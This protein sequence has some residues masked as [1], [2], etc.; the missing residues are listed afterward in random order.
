MTS[1]LNLPQAVL[2]VLFYLFFIPSGFGQYKLA[3]TIPIDPAVRTGVLP[4]GLHYYIRENHDFRNVQLRLVVNAGS[5]LEDDD[6]L[7]L[8][9]FMEHMNFNGLKHFPKNELVTYLQSIGGSIG[10][11]LNANT[12]YDATN[13]I[14]WMTTGDEKKI[15]KG[16][17]ILSDWSHNALLDTTEI[18]KERGVVLEESRLHKTAIDR[19]RLAYLPVMLNGSKYSERVPIGKDSIIQHFRPEVLHR[20][21]D[22]WY[23]PDLEA[24]IVVGDIAADDIEKKIIKHFSNFVNPANETPRP[25]VILIPLRTKPAGLVVTDKE[26]QT[27]LF[28]LYN[29]IERRPNYVTWGDYRQKIVEQL[30]NVMLDER[31]AGMTQQANA[32]FFSG[33]ASF[34]DFF[35]DYRTFS[36]VLSTGGKPLQ[37]AIDSLMLALGS[38]RQYGFLDAEL[39]RAK[40]ALLRKANSAFQ[41][42]MKTPTAELV[43]EYVNNYL[44]GAPI[45]SH[46]DQYQ[47]VQQVLPTITRDDMTALEKK[48]DIGPGSFALVLSSDKPA[49]ASTG[50][51]LMADIAGAAQLQV[52]AHQEKE[53]GHSLMDHEPQAG[54][55]TRRD[56]DKQLGT[57]NL[58]LSNGITVTL[59][60]TDF[61]NDDIRMDAW[62][63]GGFHQYPLTDKYNAMNAAQVVRAM[64][65]EGFTKTELDKFLAGKAVHV[66][67]YLNPYEDGVEGNCGAAD[68]ETFLQLVNLYLTKPGIDR[69]AFQSFIDRQESLVQNLK[70][71]P[72]AYYTDTL[73]KIEYRNNP[74]ANAIPVPAD[75]AGIDLQR[76]MEIYKGTFSNCYGMHFT[77]VGSFDAETMAPLLEKYLGSLPA[78]KKENKYTDEG[79]RPVT[80]IVQ[81]SVKKGVASQGQV[82]IIFT[83]EGPY[84]REDILKLNLL[85][86]M[87]NVQIFQQL[88]EE[89]G[90]TYN[91]SMTPVFNKRP[92]EHY[93]VTARIP[94]AP[95]NADRMSA[96]LFDIINTVRDKGVDKD[97]MNKF[98]QN[99]M[100]H[101]SGQMKTNEYWLQSLSSSWID[102]EDP[103]WMND[104]YKMVDTISAR[105]LK[106]TANKYLNTSNYIKVQLL[107][108]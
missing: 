1:H 64:G 99:M 25:A 22:T 66:Q 39:E 27:T 103:S 4:N 58:T 74:W 30:F 100:N 67:P 96:A 92:Y 82:N 91:A 83:G 47:F 19:M 75:Y 88:R 80:G 31:L 89:M 90:G 87:L 26:F 102:V 105:E 57:I 12:G 93:S 95:E 23:R 45:I 77:F 8:A 81:T 9:H 68:L 13:Y 43:G 42:S 85:V 20:F 40:S 76:S 69:A 44:A 59:K 106:E 78:A 61:K 37:P 97:L 55:I 28:E 38:I 101:H 63:W 65:I 98:K 6:Q 2:L 72:M 94:C 60:P 41:E 79:M 48:L 14:L 86:G 107:P 51:Q 73:E 3:D 16:F 24:V 108:E 17:T 46:G 71:N 52:T 84:G 18:N 62:R 33:H 49:G 104:F 21:Y 7:G 15:E 36:S 11:D 5:V 32:P 70:V 56:R 35:S 54:S 50:D 29:Y 34:E 10:A 53:I